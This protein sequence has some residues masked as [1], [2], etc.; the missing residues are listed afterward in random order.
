MDKFSVLIP[1]YK[2][3]ERVFNLVKT[4]LNDKLSEHIDKI[5][6][7]TPDKDLILP[8]SKKILLIR[9]RKRRGKYFAIRLGLKEI[10]TKI[11]VMLSSDIRIRKNFLKYLITHFKN[12]KIG[13]VVGRPIADKNS[14]IYRFSK[15][16]WDLHHLLCL[17][18][19]KGT[20]ICAFRK[21]FNYFPKISA[22]EVF[23]EY[24]IRKAG[25]KIIYEPKAY[26]YTKTPYSLKHF[27]SQRKRSFSGHLQLKKDYNFITSSMK[28]L[29]I[30]K[31]LLSLILK[32]KSIKVFFDLLILTFIELLARVSAIIEVFS[33]KY[34]I[35][36][37][38]Y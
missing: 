38:R 37:R 31:S 7:V 22:D 13:M 15:I 21:I 2:E 33:N 23:I 3:K 17:K 29:L 5:I 12:P 32:T 6:I 30:L 19:P 11:V 24:K 1:S 35:I 28:P 9:E 16:I 8:K 36:W 10:K 25:F 14:R 27:F 4:I 34:E 26:G 18:E 20:E